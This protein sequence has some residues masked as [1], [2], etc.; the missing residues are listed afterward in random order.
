MIIMSETDRLSLLDAMDITADRLR[1]NDSDYCLANDQ[2]VFR[3]LQKQSMPNLTPEQVQTLFVEWQDRYAAKCERDRRKAIADLMAF[4]EAC[5]KINPPSPPFRCVCGA[6]TIDPM[7]PEFQ[8]IHIP[9]FQAV[10][11]KAKSDGR[12]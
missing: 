6:E 2:L 9:H 7:D 3:N 10:S 11:G 12:A 5:A 1:A 4:A 8:R